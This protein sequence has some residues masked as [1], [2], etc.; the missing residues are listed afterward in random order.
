MDY[1]KC[2]TLFLIISLIKP[3]GFVYY[4]KLS[5]DLLV[6]IL[7]CFMNRDKEHI[8]LK[9]SVRLVV[10]EESHIDKSALAKQGMERC[11]GPR[12]ARTFA[13]FYTIGLHILV[14]T[15]LYRMSALS[16]L[17][18]SYL[19]CGESVTKQRTVRIFMGGDSTDRILRVAEA[20]SLAT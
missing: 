16:Y 5:D 6:F 8:Q 15:C 7:P 1:D 10:L 17:R 4:E 13:F 3:V 19:A 14:F 20:T 9:Q 12:Y 18:F 11:I 2:R